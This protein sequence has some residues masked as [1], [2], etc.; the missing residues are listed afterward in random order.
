[1][2]IRGI[3]GAIVAEGNTREAILAAASQLV[4]AI[5]DANPMLKP[6]EIASVFFTVTPDLD[7]AFPALAVRQL[8]WV[9][10]PILC[11]QEIPVPGS[12]EKCI[13]ILIHW[14][15][16][17]TQEQINHIYLGAARALRPDLASH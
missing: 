13:R 9:D 10:V 4:N 11:A 16:E 14:N 6:G 3:R 15:T 8:G 12:L 2:A 17:L 5:F 1:M 7:A